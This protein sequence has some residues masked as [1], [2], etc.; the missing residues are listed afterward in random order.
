MLGLQDAC[1]AS[2]SWA[3]MTLTVAVLGVDITAVP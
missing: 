2:S 3:L 1:V